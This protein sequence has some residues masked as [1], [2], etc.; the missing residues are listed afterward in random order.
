[1]AINRPIPKC[2]KC[3]KPKTAVHR[4]IYNSFG[5]VGDTFIR[6][7]HK[8]EAKEEKINI[9]ELPEKWESFIKSL[10]V[11]KNVDANVDSDC[12]LI[13][14]PIGQFII[15]NA[16]GVAG[17]DGQYYHYAE[18]CKLLRLQ[19]DKIIPTDIETNAWFDLL[20]SKD[21]SAS[22]AIY[23]FRLWLKERSL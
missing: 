14:E 9:P 20:I 1:M 21:C 16:K 13:P 11:I 12:Q 19:K 7:E 2:R 6:W 17:N 18:V 8:C 22:S 10:P 5:F 23:K 3:G 15:D 4:K